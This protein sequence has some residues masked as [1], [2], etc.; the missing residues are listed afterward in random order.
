MH[1]GTDQ[2]DA[3]ERALLD[4]AVAKSALDRDTLSARVGMLRN[5]DPLVR[6]TTALHGAVDRLREAAAGDPELAAAS[7]RLA[8]LTDQQEQ[9]TEQFKSRNALL[10]NSLAYFGLL[11]ARLGEVH[12]SSNSRIRHVR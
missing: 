7:D 11:S 3:A 1:T 2:A 4:F 12:Q 8:S 10:Q 5:Y 6:E 9:W